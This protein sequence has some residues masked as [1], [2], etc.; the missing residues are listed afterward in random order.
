MDPDDS[1]EQKE[2]GAPG[3]KSRSAA[4][5]GERDDGQESFSD[6]KITFLMFGKSL[7]TDPPY[8]DLLGIL[9]FMSGL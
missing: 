3:R 9:N 1:P 2:D 5:A 8:R 4:R 7:Y 6:N